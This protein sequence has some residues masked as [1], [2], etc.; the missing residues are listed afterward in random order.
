MTKSRSGSDAYEQAV[1]AGNI[2]LFG[3]IPLYTPDIP[4]DQIK[5]EYGPLITSRQCLREMG[6]RANRSVFL[7]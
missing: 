5:A 4:G 6:G 2:P 7:Y 3:I 1:K